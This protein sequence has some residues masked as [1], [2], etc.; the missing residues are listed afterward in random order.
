MFQYWGMD[1][2]GT[3]EN[4]TVDPS[5][6]TTVVEVKSPAEQTSPNTIAKD[7]TSDESSGISL[8]QVSVY[9]TNKH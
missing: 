7:E 1:K 9:G 5:K 6:D 3:K 8:S 2:N 4:D